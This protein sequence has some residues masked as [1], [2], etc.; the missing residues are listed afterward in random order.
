LYPLPLARNWVFR[1]IRRV[2]KQANDYK[3]QR[4]NETDQQPSH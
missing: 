4:Q 3:N 2:V 1:H